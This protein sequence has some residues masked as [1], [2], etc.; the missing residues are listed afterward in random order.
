MMDFSDIRSLFVYAA[1]VA[2][3]LACMM[4]LS[5]VTGTRRNGAAMGR[6]MSMPFE[7]G[8]IPTGSGHLRLPVQYYLVAMF[9]VIFDVEAAF[10]FSWATVVT[11][12]GW[13]GYG[14]A[15]VFIVFLAVSLAYLWRAGA[16]DWGPRPRVI[17]ATDSGKGHVL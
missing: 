15:L 1:V 11:D 16:L 5:A 4:G 6:S 2:V 13:V 7:S 8:I 17:P 9:F 3:L 12:T 14:A 10:L